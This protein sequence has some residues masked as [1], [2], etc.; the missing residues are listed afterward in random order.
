[1]EDLDLDDTEAPLA[2]VHLLRGQSDK[3]V[4]GSPASLKIR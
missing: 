1:M 2:H 4:D 3:F